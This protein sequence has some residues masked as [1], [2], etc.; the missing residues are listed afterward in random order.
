MSAELKT[1]FLISGA[2]STVEAVLHA[3]KKGELDG[4]QP[5]AVIASRP[6]AAGIERARSL[7]VAAYVVNR[8]SYA[9][10]HAFGQTL[11]QLLDDLKVDLL[12]QNGWLPKTPDNVIDAYKGHVL[13]QHPG[14]LD[15]GAIDFGGKGMYGIR[16][17]AARLGY[18]WLT[19]DR[20][21]HWTEATMH[22]VT[23][24]Y[25]RG[26]LIAVSRMEM[27]GLGRPVTIAEL[28][29]RFT[30]TLARESG[31]VQARLL[32]HEHELVISTLRTIGSTGEIPRFVRETPLV[33]DA[34]TSFAA[35][36][37]SLAVQLFP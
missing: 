8:R 10:A 36:A 33:P 11:L 32:P 34:Y 3:R 26:A 7:G 27:P 13:N 1:A 5:V 18:A 25:D 6:D 29:D 31:Y 28:T 22:E 35:D 19:S 9:D 2:G 37:K 12:S 24:E 21:E 20:D 23:R 16:V 14:P 30:E 15:P 17:A 4:V